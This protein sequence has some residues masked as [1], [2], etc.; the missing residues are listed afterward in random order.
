MPV[1]SWLLW[2][3]LLATAILVGYYL[4]LATVVIPAVSKAV[5]GSSAGAVSAGILLAE[6][7]RRALPFLLGSLGVFLATGIELMTSDSDP[8]YAGVG[9]LQGGWASLLLI[10]HLVVVGMLVVGSSLDGILVRVGRDDPARPIPA[11][12]L[13]TARAQA[14]LGALVL[15][16]TAAAQGA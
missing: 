4:A 8:R 14:A 13:W 11:R 16:L 5:S 10:K 6:I 15:L 3:H 2:G 9:Q 7:E 1:T 12:L